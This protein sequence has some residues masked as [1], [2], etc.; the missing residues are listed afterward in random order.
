MDRSSQMVLIGLTYTLDALKQEVATESR[1]TVFCNIT[2]V[3]GSEFLD[4]GRSGIKAEYRATMFKYDYENEKIVELNNKRYGVYRTYETNN[5]MIELY[6][7]EKAG[8]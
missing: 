5:D 2:S 8:L 3:S 1:R 4:A 6:L 7:E